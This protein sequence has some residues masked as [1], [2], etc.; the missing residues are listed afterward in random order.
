MFENYKVGGSSFLI[1]KAETGVELLAEDMTHIAF[2]GGGAVVDAQRFA[3]GY[4][5]GLS[6]GRAEGANELKRRFRELMHINS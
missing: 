4:I 5:L 6:H 2:I 3:S 1:R